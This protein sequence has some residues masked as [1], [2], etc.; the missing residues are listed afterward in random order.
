MHYN[1]K[2]F[3]RD[4]T[5]YVVL[6]FR[7]Q[8]LRLLDPQPGLPSDVQPHLP[9]V[10][11]WKEVLAK[12]RNKGERQ[13]HEDGEGADEEPAVPK[14]EVQ[15]AEVCSAQALK[16]VLDP[17]VRETQDAVG[18]GRTDGLLREQVKHHRRHE[19]ARE[20]VRRQHR[21]DHRYRQGDE[22]RFRRPGH[23]RHWQEDNANAK[24]RDQRRNG[25][26]FGRIDDRPDDGLAHGALP[27]EILDG[28]GGVIHEDADCQRQPTECH[29]VERLA[30]PVEHDDRH[31]ERERNGDEHDQ[32]AAPAA[33]E[34]QDHHTCQSRRDH[35][36]AYHTRHGGAH[37]HR[38]IEHRRDVK[39]GR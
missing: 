33:E 30:K 23:E 8:F 1:I 36:L 27:I 32:G 5:P 14:R 11:A 12:E 2:L 20:K 29:E 16:A 28:N 13:P 37:E 19:R 22:Q 35:R 6:H 31:E 34:D 3:S 25:N 26:L 17:V 15:Y 39:V 4:D 24:R 10:D 9:G 7:E 21:R 18:G 38:L